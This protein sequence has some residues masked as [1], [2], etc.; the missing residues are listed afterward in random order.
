MD[1]QKHIE[2]ISDLAEQVGK[3]V[4]FMEVCGTH[5]MSAFRSGLRSLLPESI[6]L[7]S[8]PGC[9]VCVTP[10]EYLDKAIAISRLPG[11]VIAT[12]RDMIRVPSSES[13]L[14]IERAKGAD[15]K[16]VYSPLDAL[17]YANSNP[18]KKIVFLGVVFETTA[19]TVAWTIREAAKK[20]ISNYSVLCTHK[21]MPWAMDGLLMGGDVQI[22]GF[23]CPGHVS[24]II[25]SNA[26]KFLTDKFGI[27]CVISGFEAFDMIA[28]IE[29]LLKQLV[30]NCAVVENQYSRSVT[31]EGNLSALSLL[32][33]V[34]EP[35]DIAWR[36]LGIIP[37]SG[38]RIREKFFKYDADMIFSDIDLP[39]SI[40]EKG[41]ICG[42][43]LRGT[44]TP[45]DCLLF[46][47][48]CTPDSP[49]GACMV[50]SEGTC[51]AYY[52]YRGDSVEF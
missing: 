21:T 52:K 39:K 7:L 48:K 13:S 31:P 47:K 49:L 25:G 27:P 22:D 15:I 50:S 37:K 36:G 34:F 19:P 24:V 26:Y 35:C 10:N 11:S 6:S 40:Q 8:G 3:P 17:A 12:F 28:S 20:N 23:L 41:C 14:E 45:L 16:V 9:P 32:D 4:K 2:I 33:E 42:D 46:S 44:R 30:S 29:M 5:T 18:E 38:L 43:V 1:L 51:S